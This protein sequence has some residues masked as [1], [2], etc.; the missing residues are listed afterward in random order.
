MKRSFVKLITVL[1][2]AAFTL[3]SAPAGLTSYADDSG[4]TQKLDGI[5]EVHSKKVYDNFKNKYSYTRP[6]AKQILNDFQA[7][8]PSGTHP[9]VMISKSDVNALKTELKDT[10][11]PKTWWYKKLRS[12]GDQLCDQ[13]KGASAESY[14]FSYTKCYES[15]MPGIDNSGC[16]ADQ[17][18]DRMLI[19]GMMYQLTGDV[20]YAEAADVMLQRVTSEKDFPDI[21]PWHD[22][23]FG[24][25]CQG[26]AIAYDWMYSAWTDEQKTKLEKAIVRDCFRPANDSFT[27]NTIDKSQTSANGV[28]RGVFTDHNHNP[29]VNSGIVMTAL[30]LMDK[31]PETGSSLCHDAFICLES[32]LNRYAPYGFSTEGMEYNLL[33]VDN[34]AMLF[35]SLDASIGNLYGLDSNPGFKNGKIMN[36]LNRMESDV[37]DFSFSDTY[38]SLLTDPGEL[39]LYKHY[40]MHGFRT[41]VF[42]RLKSKSPNDYTRN[43]QI[44]CWY[45]PESS[46]QKISLDK[47]L[48]TGGD[49]AFAT[50]RSGFG[51]GQSFAGL[52]AG[53]TIRDFFVHMDQG[54]FVYNALGVRWAVDL[55]KDNYNISGYMKP[56]ESDN[57][58]FKIF[59]LRPDGHNTLLINPNTTDF[60][61]E[62]EKTATISTETSSTQAK[63]VADMTDLVSSKAS[64]AKRAILLTDNRL[65]LVVRDEVVLKD[66][67]DLYWIMY[68]PQQ[69]KVSGNSAMLTYTDKDNKTAQVKLDIVSSAKGTLS[70]ESAAPWKLAPTVSKQSSNDGYTRIVYKISGVSGSVNITAKLTPQ[71]S[72][73]K[74]APDVSTYG[75]ISGWKINDTPTVPPTDN[76]TATPTDVPAADPTVAPDTDPTTVPVSDPTATPAAGQNTGTNPNATSAT[77]TAAAGTAAKPSVTPAVQN[78][79]TSGTGITATPAVTG[80]EDPSDTVAAEIQ[81]TDPSGATVFKAGGN[82]YSSDGS[83]NVIFT[84]ANPL[85][86]DLNIPSAITSKGKRYKV[87]AIAA[88]AFKGNKK[89]RS[90]IIG[91]NIR[92]IGKKHS[93]T[94]RN[95]RR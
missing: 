93:G 66:K 3:S 73:T 72:A 50:F 26:L 75:D 74:N 17:F 69:V 89:L 64:S 90:V 30:A 63:A 33:T 32:D 5:L 78:G 56:K 2:I 76:P 15:R 70:S 6:T 35:S 31:Y 38:D 62:F 71:T 45:E 22:L 11:S 24:F 53:K 55:G 79:S 37:G 28:V 49:S 41:A 92:S 7:H 65:S 14:L 67:S 43:V 87:T 19:L 34:L 9:R 61:Y 39:Y 23:D 40:G 1:S 36:T 57:R 10:S 16:A 59:R 82:Y 48:V 29:I 77:P 54:S 44:L 80:T 94:V 86:T 60:G 83:G 27:D 18:R 68:T 20:K 4:S 51:E 8:T 12:R 46:N 25:F 13:L 47:D 21:N 42:E 81:T 84:S 58:R 52:K 95:L 88:R 85:I 91:K